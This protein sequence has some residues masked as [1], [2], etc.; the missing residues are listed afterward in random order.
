MRERGIAVSGQIAVVGY[1]NWDTM[2]L[3]ARPPL[4]SV[5]VNL[6][7]IGRIAAPRRLEVIDSRHAADVHTVPCRL[8]VRESS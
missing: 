1:D 2:A 7:E 4:T 3:A 6:T 8:V 5:D